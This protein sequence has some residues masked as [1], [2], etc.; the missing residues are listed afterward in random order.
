MGETLP[1]CKPKRIRNAGTILLVT[2]H[3]FIETVKKNIAC[4]VQVQTTRRVIH[5]RP[6]CIHNS[7]IRRQG[8]RWTNFYKLKF[9]SS[10]YY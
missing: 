4:M 3:P 2:D 1:A 9:Q 5:S 6:I 8:F 10:Y 7:L